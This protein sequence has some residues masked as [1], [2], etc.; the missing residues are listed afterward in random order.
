MVPYS[1][2][3]IGA[4]G[5]CMGLK[6]GILVHGYHLLADRWDHVMWGDVQSQQLG[7]LAHVARLASVEHPDVIVF[8][9]GASEKDG[10][11]EGQ[12]CLS[13]LISKWSQLGEFRSAFKDCDMDQLKD[14]FLASA[15]IDMRATNTRQEL[16][17]AGP[18]FQA[19]GVD[20]VILVSS[21]SHA[22]RC[23]RD[24]CIAWG[25][26]AT[27]AVKDNKQNISAEVPWSPSILLASSC[28][29]CFT[30]E[31]PAGVAIVEPSHRPDRQ[32]TAI[33]KTSEKDEHIHRA[34]LAILVN[35]ILRMP[36]AK[37]IPLQSKLLELLDEE[38]N[39]DTEKKAPSQ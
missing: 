28:D 10:V 29:T 4:L 38:E 15:V 35:R 17:F 5:P 22:P 2:A 30:L 16:E 14:R 36:E 20:R 27:P 19:A 1:R 21:P 13:Y 39:G 33:F 9:S 11:R 18:I 12:Y 24:A 8:G 37:R 32:S 3:A 6:T 31:G 34:S 23:L 25:P 26:K 7:R